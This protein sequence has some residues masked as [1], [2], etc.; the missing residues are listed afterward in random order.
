MLGVEKGRLLPALVLCALCAPVAT[1]ATLPFLEDFALDTAGWRDIDNGPLTWVSS[2]GRDGG[3]YVT[4]D[5][6]VPDPIPVFGASLFRAQDEFDSSDGNFFGD[7]IAD[8]VR[9]FSYWIRHN[10]PTPL[11]VFVRFASPDN[12]PG[13]VGVDFIPV[14]PNVWTEVIIQIN[15]TSPDLILEGSPYESVFSNIGHV[16]IGII[17]PVELIGQTIT[18]DLDKASI[19]P[20]PGAFGLLVLGGLCVRRRRRESKGR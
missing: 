14:L 15:P 3:S 17:K 20:A 1:G 2:G 4:T 6:L 11:Q 19:T 16:Q 13:A 5:Y 9:E 7:W 18:V 10:A 8:G 12:F